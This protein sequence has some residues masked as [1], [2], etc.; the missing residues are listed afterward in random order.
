V[1]INEV[2]AVVVDAAAD[3]EDVDNDGNP[4]VILD[5]AGGNKG[6]G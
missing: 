3:D 1:Y 5:Q 2:S 6:T 4:T